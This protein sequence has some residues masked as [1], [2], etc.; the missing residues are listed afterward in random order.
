MGLIG[1]VISGDTGNVGL[2][3]SDSIGYN[4]GSG[5]PSYSPSSTDLINTATVDMSGFRVNPWGGGSSIPFSGASDTPLVA[6]SGNGY[7]NINDILGTVKQAT[8]LGFGLQAQANQIKATAQDNQFKSFMQ[9][10]QMGVA[11]TQAQSAATIS[12]NQAK[13]AEINSNRALQTASG[14]QAPSGGG[15]MTILAI[16]GVIIA[17]MQLEKTK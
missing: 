2:I 8:D 10:L 13:I 1:D 15:L 16:A 14:I 4:L 12:T 17:F 11:K 3:G 9:S 6:G 5:L 7:A